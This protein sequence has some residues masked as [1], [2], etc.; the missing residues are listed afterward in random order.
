MKSDLVKQ[1]E[2]SARQSEP[3][4]PNPPPQG[5][6]RVFAKMGLWDDREKLIYL[7]FL[8]EKRSIF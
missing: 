6:S 2:F 7:T 5:N 3:E 1:E 4:H 8:Q